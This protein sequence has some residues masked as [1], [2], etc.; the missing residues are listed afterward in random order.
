VR[1][2]TVCA[3][4]LGLLAL[5]ASGCA[6]SQ[7]GAAS[8]S[9]AADAASG[10]LG[11]AVLQWSG[12]FRPTQQQSGTFGGELARNQA[13]GTVVITAA[14][15]AQ[16]RVRMSANL[17]VTDPV[18]LPW[19]MAPGACGSNTLPLMTVAQFPEMTMSNGSGRLDE[20]VS[21]PFPTVGTYHV[22]VFDAGTS[23][24][25]ESDV[26]ACADLSLGRRG[27]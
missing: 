14:N 25:D 11:P 5:A 27:G 2:N 12:N 20:V 1:F 6:S 24:A 19:A 26:M 13:S 22:N 10:K 7:G 9:I 17:P 16:I 4:S 8:E 18:R 21:L 23:G 15:P 3:A